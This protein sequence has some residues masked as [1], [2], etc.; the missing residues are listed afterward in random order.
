MTS[1]SEKVDRATKLMQNLSVEKS[2]WVT[3]SGGLEGQ[4]ETVL[5][6][7]KNC[8]L[9][10]FLLIGLPFIDCLLSSSF[11]SYIGYFDEHYRHSILLPVSCTFF[12][13]S[14]ILLASSSH[15]AVCSNGKTS[16]EVPN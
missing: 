3:Q 16:C 11:M 10:F 13:T 5:G 7:T 4:L 2:R 1:V 8:L 14:P 6:G 12:H 9:C 15:S